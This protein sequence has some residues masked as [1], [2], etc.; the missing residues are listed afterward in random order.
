V[1][2]SKSGT[3]SHQVVCA[4]P[5]HR[6]GRKA[7]SFLDST[8]LGYVS[9]HHTKN[10]LLEDSAEHRTCAHAY[11]LHTHVEKVARYF[12]PLANPGRSKPTRSTS[13]TGNVRLNPH[14]NNRGK[15]ED[16]GKG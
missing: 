3:T 7:D 16:L 12:D 5:R 15:D 4:R 10:K 2:Y 13:V 6:S 8:L 1:F 11:I 9:T 14:Q